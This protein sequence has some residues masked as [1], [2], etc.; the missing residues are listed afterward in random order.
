MTR[1]EKIALPERR[2]N[3]PITLAVRAEYAAYRALDAAFRVAG[4]DFASGI[5]GGAMR[6]IGPLIGP[7]TARAR[8]NLDIAL[9]DLSEREKKAIIAA[10]WENLGRVAAEFAHLEK[11]R[12]EEGGRVVVEGMENVEALRASG[13]PAI[14]V[15]GHFAN[16]EVM[17]RVLY[18]AGVDYAL[19]YRAL[20]N[21]LI[22]EFVIA[23]RGAVMTRR[24]IPKDSG[25][26]DLLHALAQGVS[27]ALLVDQKLNG[28]VEARFFGAAAMT[29]P[30][31]A[32]LA[33]RFDAPVVPVGLQRMKGARFKVLI[34]K[35]I[36]F[37]PTGDR[38]ADSLTLTQRI[39]DALEREIRESPRDWLW[40]HRRWARPKQR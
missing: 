28:G 12:F 37:T 26:V 3:R 30:A 6:F 14:L 22:D 5:A 36:D 27:L 15:S 9:P 13:K 19:L 40:F 31:P 4:L 35:P 38:Q 10:A 17:P 34:R 8:T 1:P 7:I 11:F 20:N 24:Q 25:G 21:P 16:W 32:R 23:R 39:N 18:D 29:A 2:A 33:L